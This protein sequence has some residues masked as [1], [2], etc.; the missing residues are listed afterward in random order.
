MLQVPLGLGNFESGPHFQ[1]TY[2]G[3]NKTRPDFKT[4]TPCQ[5]GLATA[6]LRQCRQRGPTSLQ[7]PKDHRESE[8]FLCLHR[9][10]G[11]WLNERPTSGAGISGLFP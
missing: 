3:D 10:C 6:E 1:S 11:K 2:Q 9:E 7:V 5:Y 4:L 8:G